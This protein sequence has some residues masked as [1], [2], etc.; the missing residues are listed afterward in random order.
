MTTRRDLLRGGLALGVAA[1]VWGSQAHRLLTPAVAADP[2]GRPLDATARAAMNTLERR[3]TGGAHRAALRR[4]NPEWDLIERMIGGLALAC[5][6][7]REPERASR[8]APVLR[9]LALS[10][11]AA[12]QT[13]G[14]AWFLLPYVHRGT[15]RGP[16]R[17][18]FV[19]GEIGVLLG[20]ALMLQPDDV[21]LGEALDARLR[22]VRR[23]LR[24]GPLGSAESYPDE[25]W[26]YCNAT[27]LAALRMGRVLRGRDDRD[28]VRRWVEGAH[29]ALIHAD[30]GLLVSAY[31]WEG[32]ATQPPEGSSLWWS[33]H[34]LRLTAPELARDQFRRAREALFRTRLGFGYALE[35]PEGVEARVDV[36]SGGIVPGL[37]ASPASSGLALVAARSFE[38]QAMSSSLWASVELAGFAHEGGG[39]RWSLRAGNA[40]GDAVAAYAMVQGPVW[41]RLGAA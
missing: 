7:L 30:T 26:T 8:V 13:H 3:A 33:A 11:H 9:R 41:D 18:L 17:S 20:A 23:S 22:H 39:E 36:D 38:D 10:T 31:T 14:H 28:L 1:S 40:V 32:Q 6:A 4:T 24:A 2:D 37:G 25:C 12:A 5:A 27:A 19:D 35:W 21:E 16:A 34:A 15:W 29:E